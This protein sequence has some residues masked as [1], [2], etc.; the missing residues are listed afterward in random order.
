MSDLPSNMDSFTREYAGGH[1][2]HN[3][4]WMEHDNKERSSFPHTP[5]AYTHLEY[6]SKET[7]HLPNFFF[8][9]K[10][11]LSLGT[12]VFG[13]KFI[14]IFP[15]KIRLLKLFDPPNLMY[16]TFKQFTYNGKLNVHIHASRN[17]YIYLI[18]EY[19]RAF[20]LLWGLT[21]QEFKSLSVIKEKA[22]HKIVIQLL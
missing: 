5:W 7:L 10:I 4:Y 6:I 15:H 3:T 8:F 18:T 1:C 17:I 9:L 14:H 2:N 16:F 13:G 11:N 19:M 12:R 21:L 20:N 22:A